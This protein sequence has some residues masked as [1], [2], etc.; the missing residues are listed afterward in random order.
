MP[1]ASGAPPGRDP[2]AIH[3]F[4]TFVGLQEEGK[5]NADLSSLLTEAISKGVEHARNVRRSTKVS[6]TLKVE[7]SID[8]E[9]LVEIICD[10][11]S[12]LPKGKRGRSVYW[13]REDG[14]LTRQNP[15]QPNL[16][17]VV[18]DVTLAHAEVR[19]V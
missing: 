3:N 11:A 13:A 10:A 19:S 18:R 2:Y 12:K 7:A 6:V 14:T 8:E 15:S 1:D 4:S 17:G 5:L 16:P 9:G